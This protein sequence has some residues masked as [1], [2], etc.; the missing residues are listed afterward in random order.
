MNFKSV[1][2]DTYDDNE[3]PELFEVMLELITI[4]HCRL[5]LLYA[6]VEEHALM[7]IVSL[8]SSKALSHCLHPL[9]LH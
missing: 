4:S 7:H 8:I 2:D 3:F 9:P 1:L 5:V 6:C